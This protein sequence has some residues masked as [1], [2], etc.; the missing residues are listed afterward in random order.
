EPMIL[1]AAYGKINQPY[2]DW[3]WISKEIEPKK[4]IP[5][6][7][8]IETWDFK[9][10]EIK[11][12]LLLNK[13]GDIIESNFDPIL[14]QVA[15]RMEILSQNQIM[16][17]VKMKLGDVEM[18]Q[19][20]SPV[21]FYVYGDDSIE[22]RIKKF[23]ENTSATNKTIKIMDPYISIELINI[24]HA[25]KPGDLEIQI[26]TIKFSQGNPNNL[27]NAINNLPDGID[28]H[29]K[30]LIEEGS[31]VNM[32]R[33]THPN[34]FHDRCI[35]SEGSVLTIGTSINSIVSNSSFLQQMTNYPF[36]EAKF[37][38]WFSGRIFA[39]RGRRLKFETFV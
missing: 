37:D 21:K 2:Y 12:H 32:V 27:L 4:D 30:Q 13:K 5:Q 20:A 23:L 14:R 9:T 18:P 31:T 22:D 36:V 10:G 16:N 7:A 6:L 1:V 17:A 28:V 38:E 19:V 35:I 15:I 34:P 26:L 33:G 11:G 3:N 29:V 24:L 25:C 39:Y 8:R